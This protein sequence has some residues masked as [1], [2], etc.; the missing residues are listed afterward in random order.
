MKIYALIPDDYLTEANDMNLEF[1]TNCTLGKNSSGEMTLIV[2]V[3]DG[4]GK[5]INGTQYISDLILL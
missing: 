5:T 3:T 1:N 2:K 4:N